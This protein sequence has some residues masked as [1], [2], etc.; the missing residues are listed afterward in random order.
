MVE[1]TAPIVIEHKTEV[2]VDNIMKQIEAINK[3][4]SLKTIELTKQPDGSYLKEE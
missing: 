2:N 3:G 1:A 4:K